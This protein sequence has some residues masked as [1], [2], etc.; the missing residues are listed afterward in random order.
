MTTEQAIKYFKDEV[1]F[2]ERA[3]A[4]NQVHK[5]DDW[6]RALEANRAA[7]E[8]LR[9]KHDRENAVPLSDDELRGMVGEWVWVEV[10]Y[11]TT[12]QC[13]GWAYVPT[14]A[15]IT[16]HGELMRIDFCG[17]QFIA[18]RYKPK[19]AQANAEADSKTI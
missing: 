3:P 17:N 13:K 16:F 4:G 10:N 12:V 7:L 8:A 18:Y 9:E 5:T 15:V 2:C 11:G 19:E 14:P 6:V 1:R